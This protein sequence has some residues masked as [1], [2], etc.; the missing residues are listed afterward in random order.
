MN[1]GF[2]LNEL[3]KTDQAISHYQRAL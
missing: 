3:G 2:I 1:L